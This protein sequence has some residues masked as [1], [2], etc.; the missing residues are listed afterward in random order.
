M[1]KFI[2]ICLI[3][4]VFISTICGMV[5]TAEFLKAVL[6]VGAATAISAA[7]VTGLW[8]IAVDK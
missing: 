3:A 5:G 4:S 8:L 7:L 1:R 2:G 6:L